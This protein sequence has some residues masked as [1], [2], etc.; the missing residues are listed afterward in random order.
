MMSSAEERCVQC[1]AALAANVPKGLCSRCALKGALSL[2]DFEPEPAEEVSASNSHAFDSPKPFGD[3]ELLEEIAR[4][5]MGVVYKARQKS[6]DRIVAIK[7][8]LFGPMAS[9]AVIRRFRVEAVAAGGLHHPTIVT[10]HQVRMHDGQH[11]LVMDYVE[12]PNLATFVRN[13][14]LPP[15]R[16]AVYAKTIAE[17]IQ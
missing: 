2:S 5:G 14:P 9:Q 8:L 6:L 16:A 12:G 7:M 17:A 13:Q 15:R 10:I 1:G 11:F 4:G 3:Y